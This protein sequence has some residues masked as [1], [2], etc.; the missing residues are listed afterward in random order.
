M[1][2]TQEIIEPEELAHNLPKN[3]RCEECHRFALQTPDSEV[4]RVVRTTSVREI[5]SS[6]GSFT[7]FHVHIMPIV[8][9]C[10]SHF[11]VM[12]G[13]MAGIFRT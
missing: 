2:K 3:C 12:P 8:L 11:P 5:S 6:L 1:M 7:R 4:I 10:L 13:K 9:N